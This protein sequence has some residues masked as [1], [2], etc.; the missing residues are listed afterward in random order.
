[1]TVLLENRQKHITIDDVMKGIAQRAVD[2]VFEKEDFPYG[3]EVSITLVDNTAIAALNREYRGVDAATDVLSFAMM[4]GEEFLDLNEDGEAIM[5]DII[6]SMEKV[7][8]QA[9]EYGHSIEREFAFLVVHGT[10]HLLGYTHDG[11]QDTKRMRQRE[12]EILEGLG[13]TRG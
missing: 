13:L 8:D 6:I 9:E 5:G 1:M 11:Q 3:Y 10:L 4:E 2:A 12:E 7:A